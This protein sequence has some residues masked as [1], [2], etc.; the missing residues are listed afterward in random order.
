M[1][2]FAEGLKHHHP[3]APRHHHAT[4]TDHLLLAH[5]VTDDREGLLADFVLW[6]QV[7]GG[8]AVAIIDRDL[9]HEF[10]DIDGVGAFDRHLGELI[11]DEDLSR[12]IL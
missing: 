11:K 1:S 6:R 4:N 2:A 8:I 9:G 12:Y 7:V 3:L 10:L 5:G